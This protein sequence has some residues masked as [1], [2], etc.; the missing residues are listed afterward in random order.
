MLVEK[1]EL[2]AII[3]RFTP[4]FIMALMLNI[5]HRTRNL[6]SFSESID[7]MTREINIC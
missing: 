5:H 4:D 1:S 6:D 7:I 3:R 2:L